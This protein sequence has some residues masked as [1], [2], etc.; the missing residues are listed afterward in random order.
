MSKEIKIGLLVVAGALALFFG[1]NFLKG[2]GIFGGG[3]Y[4]YGVYPNS[5]GIMVSNPV[6]IKN[7][8]VG[9]VN[10]VELDKTDFE[11]VI[12]RF[13]I[14]KKGVQLPVGTEARIVS[15]DFLGSKQLSLLLSDSDEF[16][17]VND[18][19]YTGMEKE[20][21]ELVT[22]QIAPLKLKSEQLLSSLDSMV[23]MVRSI[24]D[25]DTRENIAESFESLNASFRNFEKTSLQLDNL[26]SEEKDK[27]ARIIQN[28]DSISTNWANNGELISNI[29]TNFSSVSDSL[30]ASNIASTINELNDAMADVNDITEKINLGQGSLG[31][32]I[33][34]DALYN[35]L[36]S[37][38]D[39]LDALLEDVRL[40]PERYAHF[41]VFGRK[42][43]T[44]KLTR[45]E[46][47]QLQDHLQFDPDSLKSD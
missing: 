10:E 2:A 21:Q 15:A 29:I 41:S 4:Y 20:L 26:M 23:L 12:V 1:T 45:R 38:S 5:G 36:S 40:H 37:A 16:H 14:T 11:S 27:L 6:T 17:D 25:E 46:V 9:I 30:A 34:D 7:V 39:Q 42:E 3:N 22:E 28:V 31:L 43:R 44:L 32:F 8:Q 19:L 24:L 33:N 35:R 18:T 13:T 47:K